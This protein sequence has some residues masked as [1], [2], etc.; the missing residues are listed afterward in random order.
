MI[1]NAHLRFA[2]PPPPPPVQP[3]PQLVRSQPV[4]TPVRFDA[5]RESGFDRGRPDAGAVRSRPVE[6]MR[7]PRTSIAAQPQADSASSAKPAQ[8]KEH[9]GFFSRIGHAIGGAVRSVGQAVSRIGPRVL[10]A[11][12]FIPGPVGIFARAGQGIVSAVNAIRNH[13][14]FGALTSAAGA[15]AGAATAFG[16]RVAGAINRVATQAQG[17]FQGAGIA[18][19]GIRDRNL[20]AVLAGAGA[21]AGA[22]AGPNPT[23][24]LARAAQTVQRTVGRAES[25]V[26]GYQALRDGDLAGAARG[27]ADAIGNPNS[28]VARQLRILAGDM[29]PVAAPEFGAPGGGA[30]GIDMLPPQRNILPN[31]QVPGMAPAPAMPELTMS[32]GRSPAPSSFTPTSTSAASRSVT[33][34]PAEAPVRGAPVSSVQSEAAAQVRSRAEHSLSDASHAMDALN[35][36]LSNTNVFAAATEFWSGNEGKMKEARTDLQQISTQL[37]TMMR[38]PTT[39][40]TAIDN[41][42]QSLDRAIGDANRALGDTGQ[43][44]GRAQTGA[45]VVK[46]AGDITIGTVGR[47]V[48]GLP[49][50]YGALTNGLPQLLGEGQLSTRVQN[51]LVAGGLGAIAGQLGAGSGGTVGAM[52]L[53]ALGEQ[54]ANATSR[55]FTQ[56]NSLRASNPEEL[57]RQAGPIIQRAVAEAATAAAAKVTT[58][59]GSGLLERI[60]PRAAERLLGSER[61]ERLGGGEAVERALRSRVAEVIRETMSRGLEQVYQ[62]Q[63]TNRLTGAR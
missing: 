57:R 9:R 58:E 36:Q 2:L 19:Q 7:A 63:I 10:Q 42:R 4:G 51:A 40:P 5:T 1:K 23:S 45:E 20:G 61:L 17:A 62:S 24:G 13:N 52:A 33:T 15:V 43:A 32:W 29:P 18:A 12:S 56:L 47:L 28:S 55:I 3:K 30:P 16:G 46:V 14:V 41:V 6:M 38:Y 37:S 60:G 53:R 25:A 34:R 35:R 50:A 27:A 8:R 49:A 54:G 11:A 22:V 26:S 59:L 31:L 39:S 21:A 48:P 44:L